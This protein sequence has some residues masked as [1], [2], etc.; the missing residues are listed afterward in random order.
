MMKIRVAVNGAAGN[1]GREVLRGVNEDRDLELVAAVDLKGDG[2]DAGIQAGIGAIGISLEKDLI[3]ALTRTRPDVVIDFTSPHTIMDSIEKIMSAK[4]RPVLGTTG[5]TEADLDQINSWSKKY[6]VPAVIAPNFAIGAVLMM[7]F[8]AQAARYL[9]EAEIIELHH[10]NK[11]DSP[12]GTAIKTAEMILKSRGTVNRQPMAELEK[13]KGARGG[14]IEDIHIH[15]V[16]LPGLV[17]RHE[18]IFGSIGQ[19]L[20]IRHDS[21]TRASFIPGIILAVKEVMKLDGVVY[22]LENLLNLT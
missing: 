1:M 11:I 21:S 6:G 13:V 8:V 4:A 7:L 12:S 2:S 19:T 17:A 15:S 18:V 20:T 3:P 16:R 22:G 14:R 9:P 10:E 5:I